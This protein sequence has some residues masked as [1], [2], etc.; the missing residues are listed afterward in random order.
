M[1]HRLTIFIYV[2]KYRVWTL[3][4]RDEVQIPFVYDVVRFSWKM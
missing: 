2:D 1:L 4:Y 3:T